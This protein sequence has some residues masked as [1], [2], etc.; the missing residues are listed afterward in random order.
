[1]GEAFGEWEDEQGLRIGIHEMYLAGYDVREAPS[2]WAVA[3]GKPVENPVINHNDSDAAIPWYTAYAF[4]YISDYY[5]DIDYSKLKRG[6]A[7]YAQFLTELRQADPSAFDDK[8]AAA[9][10]ATR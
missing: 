2:A 1:M 8:N 10:E 7:E 4:N 6:R 3:Q 9:H 5:S